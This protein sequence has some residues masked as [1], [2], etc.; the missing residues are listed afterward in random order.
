MIHYINHNFSDWDSQT[1]HMSRLERSIYLDMRTLY[2]SDAGV[3]NGK[4]DAS[5]FELLC[6][7][8]SC[9]S[10]DEIKALKLLL[11]D[12]FKKIGNSYR[13]A[14]WDRQIKAIQWEMKKSNATVTE[15]N[16]NSNGQV[17]AGNASGNAEPLSQAE[18][19]A[20]Y[21]KRK[22]M[23]KA[24]INKG[25]AIDGNASYDEISNAYHAHFGNGQV[26]QIVTDGNASGNGQVTD[27]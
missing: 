23:L 25:I 27:R 16:A 4:I 20:R 3:H 17:T 18:R 14:D 6:Y 21:K 9:R 11:K 19:Q 8:L 24:L 5:D 7:R 2:F 22:K 26:T 1:K 10:D 12:K 13:H 15:R